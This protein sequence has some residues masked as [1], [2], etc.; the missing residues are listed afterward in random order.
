[1]PLY[2]AQTLGYDEVQTGWFSALGQAGAATGLLVV[3]P[4]MQRCISTKMIVVISVRTLQQHLLSPR[5]FLQ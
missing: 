2:L 3:L 4:V 1:M 5:E